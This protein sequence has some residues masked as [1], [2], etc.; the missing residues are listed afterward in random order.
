MRTQEGCALVKSARGRTPGGSRAADVPLSHGGHSSG[1]SIFI[2]GIH[3]RSTCLGSAR[4]RADDHGFGARSRSILHEAREGH[5]EQDRPKLFTG[6]RRGRREAKPAD[7]ILSIFAPMRVTSRLNCPVSKL[8]VASVS[9]CKIFR[10]CR[11]HFARFVALGQ[12]L[13]I[14]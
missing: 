6:G 9:S 3:L 7:A 12:N 2:R 4:D 5:E 11:P 8:S 10:F 14:F 13:R 1:G